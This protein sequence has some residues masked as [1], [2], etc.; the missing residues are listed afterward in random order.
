M[1]KAAAAPASAAAVERILATLG[2]R[3]QRLR[4]CNL[5]GRQTQ[6]AAFLASLPPEARGWHRLEGPMPY[7]RSLIWQIHEDYFRRR[8]HAAWLERQVPHLLTGNRALATQKA[9]LVHAAARQRQ[10]RGELTDDEPVAVLEMASGLGYFAFHFLD[11]FDRIDRAEG[12]GFAPRLRYHYTDFAR[13]TVEQAAAHPA[14]AE[15]RAAGRLRFLQL[16]AR[17]PGAARTLAGEEQPL[18]GL[19]AIVANYLYNCLPLKILRRD[20]AGWQEKVVE[21]LSD[22][23]LPAPEASREPRHWLGEHD[24]EPL[25]PRLAE[26]S[27]WR[28]AD[29]ATFETPGHRQ[30]LEDRIA[31][32]PE[33]AEGED[34]LAVVSYPYGVLESMERSLAILATGGILLVSDMGFGEPWQI[35]GEGDLAPSLHGNSLAHPV[36]F[37]LLEVFSGRLGRPLHRTRGDLLLHTVML[38]TRSSPALAE[39]FAACFLTHN[40]NLEAEAARREGRSLQQREEYAAADRCYRQALEL[41]PGDLLC[42]WDLGT[43]RLALSDAEGALEWLREGASWDVFGALDFDFKSA[44]ALYR[45]G[46]LAEALDHFRTSCDR[47]P[48]AASWYNVGLIHEIQGR[49]GDAEAAFLGALELAPDDDNARRAAALQRLVGRSHTAI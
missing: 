39:E 49:Y 26:R 23:A 3:E 20:G 24:G 16:D 11:A 25:L 4:D 44:L 47:F 35:G 43:C 9:R 48:C 29:A 14:F 33:G 6:A 41:R 13:R 27:S 36:D 1:K 15:A 45:L 37:P 18:R 21:L 7:H 34:N 32:A 42:L 10:Q 31:A 30:T 38:E 22:P 2:P 8:G 19:T 5:C 28:R 12:T 46:R 17:R 40:R